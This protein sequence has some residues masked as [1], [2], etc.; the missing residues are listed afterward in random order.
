MLAS[1]GA[2]VQAPGGQRSTVV[3][4]AHFGSADLRRPL[5]CFSMA[6]WGAVGAELTSP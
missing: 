5:L 1:L 2:R 4:R 3:P 6:T